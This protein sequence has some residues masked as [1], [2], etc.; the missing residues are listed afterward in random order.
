[1]KSVNKFDIYSI[2]LDIHVQNKCYFEPKN[3]LE[4]MLKCTCMETEY[5]INIFFKVD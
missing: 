5:G 3:T 1:M 2:L 4:V